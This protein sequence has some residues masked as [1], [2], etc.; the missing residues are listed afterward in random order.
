[1][2]KSPPDS[3]NREEKVVEMLLNFY[4]NESSISVVYLHWTNGI[5]FSTY[6]NYND[7]TRNIKFVDKSFL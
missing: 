7:I 5:Y 6:K 2:K 3:S 1:M 4:I